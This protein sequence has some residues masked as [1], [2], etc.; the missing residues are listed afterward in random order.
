MGPE[1]TRPDIVVYQVMAMK[2]SN[3]P[4]LLSIRGLGMSNACSLVSIFR[5]YFHGQLNY[6]MMPRWS[7]LRVNIVVHN[8][9]D[10]LVI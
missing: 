8:S 2:R 4:R 5:V 7:N 6:V 10:A 3:N 1:R 9:L